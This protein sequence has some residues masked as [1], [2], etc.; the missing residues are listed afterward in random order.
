MKLDVA[1]VL[2]SGF[3]TPFAP[4]VAAVEDFSEDWVR[5]RSVFRVPG[6]GGKSPSSVEYIA[7]NNSITVGVS[8]QP[9]PTVKSTRPGRRSASSSFSGW[10]VVMIRIRPSLDATPS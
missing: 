8:A 4:L 9:N 7:R 1:G 10:L 6:G 3:V 5:L 2:V